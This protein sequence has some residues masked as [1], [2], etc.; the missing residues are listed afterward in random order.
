MVEPARALEAH[1]LRGRGMLKE[2]A[3]AGVGGLFGEQARPH[4]AGV[5]SRT[6][7]W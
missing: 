4:A 7:R 2:Q 3:R 1:M 5:R 6:S